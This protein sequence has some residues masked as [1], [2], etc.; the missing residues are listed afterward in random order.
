MFELDQRDIRAM[1]AFLQDM[2]RIPSYS[3]Q[4]K[5]M[6]ERLAAEMEQV[7][8]RDVR[9]DRIGNVIGRVGAGSGP[10][11]L[12]NGHIDVVGVGDASSWRHDPFGAEI[13]NG[14]LYGRGAADMKGSLAAMVYGVKALLDRGVRLRGEL[15]MAGVVQEEPCEG[16]GMRILVEEEGLI[17]DY[18]LLGEATNLQICRGQ[19]GRME[20]KVVVQGRSA[21]ASTPQLGDNAIYSAARLIFG[22]EMLSTQLAEDP[23]LGPGTLAI[24]HIE[25]T[26]GS[27]NVVPDTCTF[28]IDRRLTLGETEAKARAEIQSVVLREEAKALI[29]VPEYASVSYTG[30]RAQMTAYYPAWVLDRD[31]P[32]VHRVSKG[33]RAELGYRP[34]IGKWSFST[35]GVYT[36]GVA[37]IPTVGFG[38]GEERQAH[39]A[40]ERIRLGDVALAARG[41]ASIAS[42]IL[43]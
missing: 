43:G 12:Y 33:I 13:V 3:G 7:G 20:L 40:D 23:F 8:F 37:G 25:N 5:E 27:R 26:A 29:S 21:H 6:A 42:H 28:Y 2:I 35:D 16:L 17:P 18:V 39:S 22:I 30:H 1:T 15:Y 34:S 38:P 10:V 24:T 19:R 31:H 4:E 36:M 41:Y 9:M 32:L 14:V 11:L